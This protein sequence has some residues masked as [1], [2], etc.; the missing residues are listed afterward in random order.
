VTLR[1]Q[2]I[3]ATSALAAKQ[4]MKVVEKV[5][6]VVMSLSYSASEG[7]SDSKSKGK[8]S[9]LIRRQDTLPEA[10]PQDYYWTMRYLVNRRDALIKAST[11]LLQQ[12]HD[13]IQNVYPQTI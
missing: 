10:K 13:Q 11:K 3:G 12:F 8:V 9:V 4:G 2:T 7:T 1:K 6:A 5:K